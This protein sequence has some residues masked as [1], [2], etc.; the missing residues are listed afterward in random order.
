[1]AYSYEVKFYND[2]SNNFLDELFKYVSIVSLYDKYL[3]EHEFFLRITQFFPFMK[4]L[5][6][7]NR[8]L[9][10]DNQD[11]SII[12]YSYLTKLNLHQVHDD[13][14]E[15]LLVNMNMCL[16]NDLYLSVDYQSLDTVTNS[17]IRNTIR[18]NCAKLSFLC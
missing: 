18:I 13:Y 6:I 14:V 4:E 11:L 8:K 7:V 12:E 1:M 3:F 15:Q 2:I 10:N 9:Q 5:T 17:F 16:S